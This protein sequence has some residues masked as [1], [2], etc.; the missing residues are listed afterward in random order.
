L[1]SALTICVAEVLC[2]GFRVYL[3]TIFKK[4]L[5]EGASD[6]WHELLHALTVFGV[7]RRALFVENELKSG[8]NGF[9]ME[10]SDVHIL[11]QK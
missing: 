7:E 4:Q 10:R 1:G 6:I 8:L 11:V 9:E 2:Q 5:V 3:V